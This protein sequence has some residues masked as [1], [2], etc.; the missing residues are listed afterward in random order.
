MLEKT[1]ISLSLVLKKRGSPDAFKSV[2]E[3]SGELSRPPLTEAQTRQ[4][5]AAPAADVMSEEA[6][7]ICG[8][9][10]RWCWLDGRELCRPCLVLDR[11]PMTLT[12]PFTAREQDARCQEE[13]P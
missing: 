11:K 7:P 1:D 5:S 2:P 12:S 6:C 10:E 9:R 3:P 4:L 13:E 8:S